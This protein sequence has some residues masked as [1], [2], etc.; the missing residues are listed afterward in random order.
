MN[1]YIN[2]LKSGDTLYVIFTDTM[3]YRKLQFRVGLLYSAEDGKFSILLVKTRK[4]F[5]VPYPETVLLT[6]KLPQNWRDIAEQYML[7]KEL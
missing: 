6:K 3:T 1:K 7:E 2:G 5:V 4:G